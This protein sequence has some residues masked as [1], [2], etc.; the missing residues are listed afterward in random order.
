MQDIYTLWKNALDSLKDVE[1]LTFTMGFFPFTKALLVNSQKTGGNA[2]N[3]DPEDGPLLGILINVKWT[4]ETDDERSHI[5][6]K[7]FMV[8][9]RALANEKGM[10]HRYIFA[11]YAYKT[12]DVFKGYGEKSL[13]MLRETSR[14]YD[15]SGI[16]QKAV[17]GGFKLG[18][19]E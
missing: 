6:V 16:F 12:D 7:A 8:K 2:M 15:S 11:N 13:E 19:A 18:E 3:I 17:P 4:S 1:G 10:L 9:A 14:K 5:A